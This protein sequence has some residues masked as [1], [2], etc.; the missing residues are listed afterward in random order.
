MSSI[1]I[2]DFLTRGILVPGIVLYVISLIPEMIRDIRAWTR[3]CV[4]KDRKRQ[5]V[6]RTSKKGI[7]TPTKVFR[8]PQRNISA[9]HTYQKIG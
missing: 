6:I 3:E 9:T 1:T 8:Y 5:V 7:C 4:P 2:A